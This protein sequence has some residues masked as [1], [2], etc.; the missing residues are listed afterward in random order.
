MAELETWHDKYWIVVINDDL[1]LED[2]NFWK[3]G[4]LRFWGKDPYDPDPYN[5]KL[6][7][8]WYP[9]ENYSEYEMLDLILPKYDDC[10][11][12]KI[13]TKAKKENRPFKYPKNNNNN[14]NK[15]LSVIEKM[16]DK[17]KNYFSSDKANPIIGQ[18]ASVPLEWISD[19]LF[20]TLWGKGLQGISGL[21]GNILNEKITEE[22]RK[23][24]ILR[25]FLTRMMYNGASFGGKLREMSGDIRD[26]G[27]SI[28][29]GDF[30]GAFQSILKDPQE[31]V[32]MLDE[33]RNAISGK[34]MESYQS[35]EEI[36]DIPQIY[37]KGGND[38]GIIDED[39]MVQY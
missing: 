33:F 35:T 37:G 20:G 17:I 31:V 12:C 26:M 22:G 9:R 13:G 5:K 16:I 34:S 7:Y 14:N 11:L 10:P 38:Y 27:A 36:K 29:M 32:G 6:M 18:G 3:K 39:D 4:I 28:K 2:T 19:L 24:D 1:H 21:V 30:G 15:I 23:K 8:V 25:S